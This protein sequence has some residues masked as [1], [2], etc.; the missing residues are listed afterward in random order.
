MSPPASVLIVTGETSGER[1]AAGLI[2]ALRGGPGRELQFWGSGG[3]A[4]AAAGAEL[5]QDVSRLAAIGPAAA[6]LQVRNYIGWFRRILREVDRRRPKLAILVDFPDFNLPLARRLKRRGIP[7]CW[8]IAPQVW[9]WRPGRVKQIRRDI[10]L[11]LVIFPFEEGYFRARE[12]RACYVGNPTA[13]RFAGLESRRRTHPAEPPV[14]LLMPGSRGKEVDLILP[15]ELDAA[16]RLRS[17]RD[18]RIWVLKAP[19]IS[20]DRLESGLDEWARH[21][22]RPPLGA[23]IRTEPSEEVLP[24][25]DLA[26][27]KSGTGTLEAMLAGTPFAMVYRMSPVSWRLLRPLVPTRTYCLANLVAGETVAP[28]FVQDEAEGSRIARYLD[29]LLADS[30]Q[31]RECR[32]RLNRAASTLGSQPAY[33]TAATRIQ[34][35]FFDESE[36]L[37]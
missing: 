28:E 35:R 29:G 25:A 34:E 14:L 9:A 23:V 32:L 18:V 15:V 30:A 19:G 33:E 5:L 17:S 13:A 1:H 24:M 27:V 20:R 4:M 3:Q 12:V 21:R 7:V 16:D 31:Y 36:S 22:K 8:F 11:M 37:G 26:V 6:L 2:Q 10:D